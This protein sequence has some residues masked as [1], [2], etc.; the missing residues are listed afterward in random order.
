MWLL[1]HASLQVESLQ[2]VRGPTYKL[3]Q[4]DLTVQ[5]RHIHRLVV[6]IAFEKSNQTPETA[7]VYLRETDVRATCMRGNPLLVIWPQSCDLE[8]N[9]AR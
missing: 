4:R 6:G 1:L 5:F 9:V 7:L 2:I 3:W 8:R